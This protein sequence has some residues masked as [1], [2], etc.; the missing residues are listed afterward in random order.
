MNYIKPIC[1]ALI[2]L[3][4]VGVFAYLTIT[5]SILASDLA[6]SQKDYAT[7]QIA[8]KQYYLES[9]RSQERE[10]AASVALKA[11]TEMANKLDAQTAK[12]K[13]PKAQ[14]AD[15]CA[16]AKALIVKNVIKGSK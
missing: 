8:N 16:I 6:D 14:N 7:C 1:I 13:K 11:A 3:S 2:I 9:Q 5:K 4:L 12:I 10:K 15:D